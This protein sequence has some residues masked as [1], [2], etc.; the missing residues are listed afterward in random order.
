MN[1]FRLLRALIV[2]FCSSSHA[3]LPPVVQGRARPGGDGEEA[4]GGSLAVHSEGRDSDRGPGSGQAGLGAGLQHGERA[5]SGVEFGDD[6][7]LFSKHQQTTQVFADRKA[8][9]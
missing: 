3:V 8:S 4:G 7:L 1:V 2:V 9:S 6:H 5:K